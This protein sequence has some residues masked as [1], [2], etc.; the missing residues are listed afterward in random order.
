MIDSIAATDLSSASDHQ[1]TGAGRVLE[2]DHAIHGTGEDALVRRARRVVPAMGKQWGQSP[3]QQQWCKACAP[4]GTSAAGR[5]S[6]AVRDQLGLCLGL[7]ERCTTAGFKFSCGEGSD[8]G[9]EGEEGEELHC[10]GVGTGVLKVL[11]G[12]R[13]RLYTTCRAGVPCVHV[14]QRS[15]NWQHAER[16]SSMPTEVGCG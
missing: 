10:T 13:A 7:S 1:G 14:R 15:A 6:D 12:K 11:R 3:A 16:P 2:G 5:C 4:V 8:E 9:N